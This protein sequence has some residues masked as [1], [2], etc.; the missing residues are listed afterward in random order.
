VSR[1]LNIAQQNS[2]GIS[3]RPAC[4]CL[5]AGCLAGT[6]LYHAGFSRW[7]VYYNSACSGKGR[8]LFNLNRYEK[9]M[10]AHAIWLSGFNGKNAFEDINILHKFQGKEVS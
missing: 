2:S 9:G 4:S 10:I 8:V 5:H 7:A 6:P 1:R 3:L